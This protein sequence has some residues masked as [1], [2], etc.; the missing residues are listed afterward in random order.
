M[1][2]GHGPKVASLIEPTSCENFLTMD[3]I[4]QEVTRRII[5]KA[6]TKKER[7]LREKWE[8]GSKKT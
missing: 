2:L 8:I 5:H 3:E 6:K 7:S 1:C 4:I